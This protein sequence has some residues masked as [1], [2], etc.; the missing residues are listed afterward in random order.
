MP[1]TRRRRTLEAPTEAVW[2]V[3]A[4]PHHLPRWWPRAAR[5]EDVSGDRWTLVLATAKGRS[6]RADYRLLDSEAPTRRRFAQE[7]E[8]SP[9]ARMLRSSEVE[10]ALAD[11]GGGTEVTVELAQK[12]RGTSRLGGFM[13]RGAA[14]RTL[15]EALESLE[16]AVVG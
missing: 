10:V 8:G 2:A 5:V 13:F 11:A 3:V 15:D 16:R 12:L 7:I 6:V 4:D 14:R 9:F 1:T